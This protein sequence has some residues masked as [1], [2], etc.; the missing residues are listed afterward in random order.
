MRK[1]E[2]RF[3]RGPGDERRVGDLAEERGRVY[4]E[5][6]SEWCASGYSLSPFRIPFEA[7]LFE[8]RD[9]EF[10]PL[11]G[12][13]ADS[14][15]D[16]WGLLLM[17]RHFRSTGLDPAAV[18]PLD[19]LS[20]LGTRTMG[21]L[22][23]HP[24][25][26]G[27]EADARALDLHELGR[28]V[29]E[30]L[31]GPSA[32]VLPQLLRAGGSPAGARPKVVV[33]FDPSSG[34]VVSGADD[35]PDRLE[36]WMVK[37]ASREDPTDAGAIEYAYSLMAAAAGIDMPS[38]R[39]FE[40]DAGDRFFGVRRFDREGN[41]RLHVHTF[42]NLIHSDFRVPSAD[43]ADLLR[44]TSVLTRRHPDVLR[45]W[46]RAAFNV[47]AH[48]RD[49]HVKNF[50][51]ILDDATG[52]WTLSPAYDLTFSLGP[53]GEHTMAVAGEAVHPGAAQLLAL[54]SAAGLSARDARRILDEVRRA[55]ARWAEWAR[56]AGVSR[57]SMR[58]IGAALSPG[59]RS[60][61]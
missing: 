6:D 30:V 34:E 60:A 1:L 22:T 40:T 48:S 47:L 17:D 12:L 11:P 32:K 36:H 61:R 50:A 49:D 59:T 42:G 52:G 46:R 21:A 24:P 26:T 3:T 41:R 55:V 7:R 20:W 31:A 37:F 10:G 28:Q 39:L 25:A 18:G 56:R 19:R 33:G 53:G 51:F 27:P 45:A 13:F 23:Y 44:A 4:F 58:R 35:L 8:H 9:R 29:Q 43:Y 38:T 57:G 2:V 16:G 14:L 54:A 15:P 5:Y